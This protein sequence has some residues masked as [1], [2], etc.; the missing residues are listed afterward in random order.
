MF[1]D[2]AH[3]LRVLA[4]GDEQSI[5]G[6]HDHKILYSD[7][8]NKLFWR[9]DEV[10]RSFQRV[11]LVGAH[12]IQRISM[13][14]MFVESRPG[15]K[16]IPSEIGGDAKEVRLALALGGARFEHGIV[17]R[18]VF[19]LGI[20]LLERA[21]EFSRSERSRD[22][23]EIRGGLRK[24]LAHGVGQRA[25][26]PD[27]HA[28]VPEI[29]ARLQKLALL[30]CIRLFGE[31]AHTEDAVC[32]LAGLDVTV[33]GLGTRGLYA[34][35]DYVVAGARDLQ[36]LLQIL[37]EAPLVA[38]HVIRGK[39][40]DD[41]IR[42]LAFDQKCREA[43]GWRGIARRRLSKNLFVAQSWKLRGDHRPQVVIGD[44]PKVFLA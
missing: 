10:T 31:A 37:A 41:R 3:V 43:N 44:D 42:I 5:V 12:H 38:D 23:F 22:L 32:L 40:P 29:V 36:R 27:E 6:V 26:T 33:S 19:A 14:G 1:H 13:D 17:Y 15:A 16:V 8:G 25:G 28:A 9:V 11:T 18:D 20:K 39:H 35:D 30:L 7:H 2:L 34:H 24:V 4:G 21:F